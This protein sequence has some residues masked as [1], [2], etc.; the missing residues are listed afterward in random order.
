MDD[1]THNNLIRFKSIAKK[2]EGLF[3][4]FRVKGLKGGTSFNTTICVD[5]ASA[6]VGAGDS[7]EK[8]IEACAKIAAKEYKK[9]ELQFEGLQSI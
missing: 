5:I 4:N 2:K 1:I 9:A 6:E 8:I 7:L 3:S